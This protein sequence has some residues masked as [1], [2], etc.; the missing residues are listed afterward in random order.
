[1]MNGK[2]RFLLS[3]LCVVVFA[4]P[5]RA[6]QADTSRTGW[7]SLPAI[8]H[9]IQP[10]TFPNRD[11]V[12]TAFGAVGDSTTDCTAAF[13]RAIEACSE[14]GGGRVVVPKGIYLTGAIHLRSNVNLYLVKGGVV[15]FSTNPKDYLP[16][17]Y[18]RWEGVECMNYSP[19]LYAY[20]QENIAVTGNGVF[21]GQ[22]AAD[23]WWSWKG[24]AQDGWKKGMPNQKKARTML[25]ALAEKG[26]PVAKR[27]FGEGSYLR[28]MFVQFYHCRNILIEGVTFKDSPMW[29]LHPVLSR[30]VSVIGVTVEGL[31]P[32]NDG[33]DPESCTD[34][35]IQNCQFDTGDDC[36]AIKSGRNADGR[37]VD[38][39]SENIVIQ[40]CSMKDGHGGVVIGSEISGGVRNIFVQDCVMDSP[41]LDRAV[42]IKTNSV[43]GGV[44]EGVYAR[45]IR[46]GQVAEAVLKINFFYEEGDT[47]PFTPVVRDI[48]LDRVTCQK[49]KYAIWIKGYERSPIRNLQFSD[50]VFNGI[51]EPNVLEA[52]Q[53]VTI[54]SVTLNGAPMSVPGHKGMAE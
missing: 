17:V 30:N 47:G 38:V 49:G 7:E 37:R 25:F 1:M 36:I 42:R 9:R 10:P 4:L 11:F 5:A 14:A 52:V 39:P 43:R 27:L 23:N 34:V 22:G 45:N 44:V 50:C 41:R 29:F 28:P 51:A 26:V 24:N 6:G 16:V 18:T 8:L 32:N 35:L 15:R 48:Y 12:I 46:V 31:G 40:G 20:E 53:G 21:D 13:R 54:S 19:L 2:P 3:I 33:C